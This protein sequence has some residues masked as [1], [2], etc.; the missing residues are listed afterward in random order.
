MNKSQR[1]EFDQGVLK[2]ILGG[3]GIAA[4]LVFLPIACTSMVLGYYV[5]WLLFSRFERGIGKTVLSVGALM[6]GS[7]FVF[8]YGLKWAFEAFPEVF[9][10]PLNVFFEADPWSTEALVEFYIPKFAISSALIGISIGSYL[11]FRGVEMES[12]GLFQLSSTVFHYTTLPF[13][14]AMLFAAAFPV[15]LLVVGL[16]LF[17]MPLFLTEGLDKLFSDRGIDVDSFIELL[18]LGWLVC[19]SYGF[20]AELIFKPKYDSQITP[21][22]KS[23]GSIPIGKLSNGRP[24]NLSWKDLNVH[25]HVLGQPGAG[26]STLL[27]NFYIGSITSGSGF[28]MIDLKADVEVR[29]EIGS[30]CS[31][32]GRLDDLKILDFTTPERSVGYNPL[33]RGNAS[34]LRDRLIASFDWSEEYYKKIAEIYILRVM[35]ALVVVRD[36]LRKVPTLEDVYQCIS[37]PK[38]LL[39]LKDCL[40]ENSQNR[41]IKSELEDFA[42]ELRKG[43]LRE[44]LTG[45]K[46]DLESVL[47]SE[48]GPLLT[49]RKAVDLFDVIKKGQIFYVLLDGQTFPVQSLRIGRMLL[50]DLRAAS[51]QIVSTIEKSDR[52]RFLV[53]IDEFADLVTSKDMGR[54]FTGFLIRCRGSGIGVVIAHQSLGDF[55]DLQVAKQVVDSTNTVISFVQKDPE[56]CETL[57]SIAGTKE[58][59]EK[60]EQTSDWLVL[61]DMDT[62]RGTRIK[63]EEFILHPNEFKNLN[64][65]EALYIAKKPA[66]FGRVK[67]HNPAIEMLDESSIFTSK[68]PDGINFLDLKGRLFD[69]VGIQSSIEEDFKV[70]MGKAGPKRARRLSQEQIESQVHLDDL[71]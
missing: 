15:G 52:S 17:L 43:Q 4:L 46:A 9:L 44:S 6:F 20:L 49:K 10:V 3:C 12:S 51:G 54:L 58:T 25:T 70:S 42:R 37:D 53:I 60:T 24:L 47:R 65:G 61:G 50:S 41:G 34:E 18:F 32:Y 31:K 21:V 13:R 69:G 5:Y 59:W 16:L 67:V 27:K 35:R 39:L 48:M 71:T 57:A 38:A 63:G 33:L 1:A 64:I 28:M 40:P 26:K 56:S 2:L 23:E 45:I 62:G 30:L 8:S 11:H 19:F 55:D 29:R 7:L 36:E 68:P 66:R 14:Y 22:K